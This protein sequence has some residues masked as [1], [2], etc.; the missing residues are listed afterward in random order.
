MSETKR[1]DGNTWNEAE[2]VYALLDIDDRGQAEVRAHF[3][4]RIRSLR[5]SLAIETAWRLAQIR[6]QSA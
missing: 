4:T 1:N 2:A 5:R 6:G 3:L